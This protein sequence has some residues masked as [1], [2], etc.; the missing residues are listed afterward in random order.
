MRHSGWSNNVFVSDNLLVE[1]ETDTTHSLR[2]D[3]YE[4]EDPATTNSFDELP[5]HS[6]ISNDYSQKGSVSVDSERNDDSPTDHCNLPNEEHAADESNSYLINELSLEK[7]ILRS[8]ESKVKYGWSQ[9]AALDQLLSLF[10]LIGDEKIPYKDWDSVLKFLRGIGYEDARHE[11]VCI[12]ADHVLLLKYKEQCCQCGK[13]WKS[14]HDYYILGL[15]TE[16]IF[17]SKESVINRM[18]HWENKDNWFQVNQS[19]WPKR[20]IWDGERFQE[21]SYFWDQDNEFQLPDFCPSC[22]EVLSCEEINAGNDVGNSKEI[23]CPECR[24]KVITVPTFVKGSPLNQAFLFHEDGFN[25][26]LRKTRG[27]AAINISSGCCLKSRRGESHSVYSFVPTCFLPEKVVHKFD[28]FLEPLVADIANLYISGVEV[29]LTEDITIAN[30]IFNKGIHLIRCLLLL[31]T[32]DIKAHAEMVLYATGMRNIITKIGQEHCFDKKCKSLPKYNLISATNDGD[33]SINKNV[34]AI[35]YTVVTVVIIL[36]ES[37]SNEY[38]F[39]EILNGHENR[40]IHS[41]AYALLFNIY[42]ISSVY[43]ISQ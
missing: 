7:H 40:K 38:T 4:L 22:S 41:T 28:A 19:V 24:D 39:L 34:C 17:L 10:N 12:A 16:S 11:K 43:S 27:V 20:E 32:A 35:Q 6:D 29:T 30:T 14:A 31:G 37:L 15:R 42:S 18:Q 25:A 13:T 23:V 2:L 21:L 26:F 33:Q 5:I 36:T 3:S 9:Q 8:L 1:N